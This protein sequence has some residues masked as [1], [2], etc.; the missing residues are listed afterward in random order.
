MIDGIKI[1][2]SHLHILGAFKKRD[3]TLIQYLDKYGIDKAIITTLNQAAS[4]QKITSFSNLKFDSEAAKESFNEIIPK[5]QYDHVEVREL[6]QKNPERFVG[7]Y[8]FNPRIAQD[9]ED[10]YKILEKYIKDYGFKG[11]KTQ[12]NVDNLKIKDYYKLAEFLIEK[13]LPLYFHSGYPFFFQKNI[14]PREISSFVDKYPKLKLILGH[15]GFTMEYCINVLLNL[16]KTKN[17]YFETSLSVPYA[18]RTLIKV[19]GIDRVL[20]GS[21]S[22]SATTPDIEIN[23]IKIL[24]L[25]KEAL[26]K[27]FYK[28]TAKLLGID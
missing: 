2:D 7:F 5:E 23:K 21:D 19:M 8:W 25:D 15:A 11:V 18:I 9:N 10:H 26:E 28:N 22:P 24:N 16:S 27:V 20:F 12:W 13:D 17:V 6:V 3:M 14:K 4:F 1:F